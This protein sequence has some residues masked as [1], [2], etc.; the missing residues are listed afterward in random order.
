MFLMKLPSSSHSPLCV[1]AANG[2]SSRSYLFQ[3]VFSE[4]LSTLDALN[5]FKSELSCIFKGT[6]FLWDLRY[7]ICVSFLISLPW[8]VKA[9]KRRLKDSA[10]KWG[11]RPDL[12]VLML[13]RA[14]RPPF[15]MLLLWIILW[16]ERNWTNIAEKKVH[17]SDWSPDGLSGFHL[18]WCLLQLLWKS[19]FLK[20]MYI[21][22][23]Q[24]ISHTCFG[25]F[26]TLDAEMWRFCVTV[27]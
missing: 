23:M 11:A 12:S 24:Y 21:S 7:S 6:F 1:G 20:E 18:H 17:S 15:W 19:G 10:L 8:T 13:R 22:T 26:Y 2:N 9:A 14:R 25:R 3:P 16:K 4:I 5:C 27:V